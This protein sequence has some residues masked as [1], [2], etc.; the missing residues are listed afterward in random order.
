MLDITS[1]IYILVSVL[2]G[3]T[4]FAWFQFYMEYRGYCKGCSTN[5]CSPKLRK[6]PFMSK[7]FVGA[8]FFTLALGLALRLLYGVEGI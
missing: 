8:V 5:T 2:A 1:T 4:L 7:C 3:G 6:N